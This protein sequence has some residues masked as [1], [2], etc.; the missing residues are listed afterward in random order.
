MLSLFYVESEDLTQGL[1]ANVLPNK[2]QDCGFV[3]ASWFVLGFH[4]NSP[5]NCLNI[6]SSLGGDKYQKTEAKYKAQG[7]WSV[8]Q[9]SVP[10]ANARGAQLTKTQGLFWLPVFEVLVCLVAL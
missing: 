7:N 9:L 10:T 2:P 1:T 5:K 3:G 4:K 8:S 6:K